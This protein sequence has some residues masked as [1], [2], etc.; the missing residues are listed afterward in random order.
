MTTFDLTREP[1]IKV[2][3]ASGEEAELSLRDVFDRAHEITRLA[4]ELATQDVAILRLLLAILRRSL[5]DRAGVEA[6][7]DL[8]QQDGLDTE[9]VHRYLDEYQGRFDL[10]HPERPFYQVADLRTAKGGFTELARLIADMPT[11]EKFFTNRAGAGAATIPLAEAARWVVHTQAMDPS[12]IK[13]GAIGDDTVKGGKGYPIGIGWC[14]WLGLIVV[15]GESLYRTLLLNLPWATTDSDPDRDLP[16]WE[17][18]APQ[19]SARDDRRPRGP[20]D[21]QTWQSRRLRLH[22]ENAS[23]IGILICNGDAL[24]PRN[25]FRDEFMTSWRRSE[26]QMK[27]LGTAEDVWMPRAHQTNRQIWRSL[28]ALLADHPDRGSEMKQGRWQEWLD[29]LQ[30]EG[31]LPRGES[32]RLRCVGM[33]YGSQSSTTAD[34]IDDVLALPL[35]VL[36]DPKSRRAAIEAV[37]D[38]EKFVKRLGTLAMD[39]EEASGG[40]GDALPPVRDAA[41]EEAYGCLDEP[42]RRWLARLQ[43]GDDPQ[44]QRRE[45]QQQAAQIVEGVGQRLLSSA[46]PSA[47]IGHLKDDQT[48]DAA[49]ADRRFRAGLARELADLTPDDIPPASTQGETT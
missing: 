7:G 28:A 16:V 10:L 45:W 12:G 22:V 13:S 1:W 9:P 25:R 3:L 21:L 2:L 47:W 35:A 6:W 41:K 18:D 40:S 4:G 30:S 14:G 46:S 20:A 29:E 8:W 5:R 32:V 38:A 15:E 49:L 34:V 31:E 36:T 27:A 42:Y 44:T 11:G 26:A 24:H 37:V 33:E 48:K 23:A 17:L 39:I 19:S 43:V